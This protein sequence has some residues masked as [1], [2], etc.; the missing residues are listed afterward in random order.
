MVKSP[1][2][3]QVPRPMD[4]LYVQDV[5]WLLHGH[6]GQGRQNGASKIFIAKRLRDKLNSGRDDI[7]AV[8]LMA[9]RVC[10]CR[11]QAMC[12]FRSVYARM[13]ASQCRSTNQS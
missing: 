8:C 13:L 2:L 10:Q 11:K 9:S 7:L 3:L 1:Q 4:G 5:A 6:S 12:P